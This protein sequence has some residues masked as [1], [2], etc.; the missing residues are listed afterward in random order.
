MRFGLALKFSDPVLRE[1][2]LDTGDAILE[3]GNMWNDTFWGIDLNTGKGQNHLG[4]LLME[5]R[6][7]LNNEYIW[8]HLYE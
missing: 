8:N 1:M 3:E 2:L 7:E 6:A 4:R 5:R